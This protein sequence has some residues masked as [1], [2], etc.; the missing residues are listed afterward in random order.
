MEF[1]SQ[2]YWSPLEL[3]VNIHTTPATAERAKPPVMHAIKKLLNKF[4]II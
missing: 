4:V 1:D 2:A 3:I